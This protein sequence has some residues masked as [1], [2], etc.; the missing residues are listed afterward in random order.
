MANLHV[1]TGMFQVEAILPNA[2]TR[3]IEDRIIV[4]TEYPLPLETRR[5]LGLK[6]E[7]TRS[8]ANQY[9]AD[10]GKRVIEIGGTTNFAGMM[11]VVRG[12]MQEDLVSCDLA[13]LTYLALKH[14]G[15]SAYIN[16]FRKVSSAAADALESA[17]RLEDYN[18]DGDIRETVHLFVSFGELRPS[19]LASKQDKTVIKVLSE[20]LGKDFTYYGY[21]GPSQNIGFDANAYYS[22]LDKK[23]NKYAISLHKG[24]SQWPPFD[25]RVYYNLGTSGDPP[26]EI[27]PPVGATNERSY[28]LQ[29]LSDAATVL[30]QVSVK[31]M[32]S[33]VESR[34]GFAYMAKSSRALDQALTF[35]YESPAGDPISLFPV[36]V[37]YRNVY[38]I[39]LFDYQP[40]QDEIDAL[41]MTELEPDSQFAQILPPRRL[42]I[43]TLPGYYNADGISSILAKLPQGVSVRVHD[44]EEVGSALLSPTNYFYHAASFLRKCGAPT[45]MMLLGITKFD[46]A[47]T[48]AGLL[49]IPLPSTLEA[50]LPRLAQY[51]NQYAA[52]ETALAEIL[53][54]SNLLA[55]NGI[56]KYIVTRVKDYTLRYNMERDLEDSGLTI[57]TSHRD[58]NRLMVDAFI[59][60]VSL[61]IQDEEITMRLVKGNYD[62][63]V[64]KDASAANILDNV[65]KAHEEALSY[66][67]RSM[68]QRIKTHF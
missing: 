9:A 1:Y 42:T 63:I 18:D 46:S 36:E 45:D 35:S 48:D 49:E 24:K 16:K 14:G 64:L 6:L 37:A 11:D 26:Y 55:L 44:F 27:V 8:Q 2:Y 62:Y 47:A 23:G 30:K 29:A 43:C 50:K 68:V 32:R 52:K 4:A 58:I 13:A 65:W 7:P 51:L 57:V 41:G 21:Y 33:S 38:T 59:C 61:L 25:F 39:M 54:R 28:V 53:E 31:V 56:L 22:F 40:G 10:I 17:N 3:R 20:A 5:P 66:E 60:N 19:A 15:G 12:I 34:G 67:A